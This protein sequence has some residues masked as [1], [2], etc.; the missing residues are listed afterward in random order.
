MAK[1]FEN[2]SINR[3]L[4]CDIS[5][6]MLSRGKNWYEKKVLDLDEIFPFE[7]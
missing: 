4:A 2:K 6:K 5:E 1:F 3:Y 7:D